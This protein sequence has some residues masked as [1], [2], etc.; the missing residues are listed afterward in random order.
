MD[1]EEFLQSRNGYSIELNPDYHRDGAAYCRAAEIEVLTPTLFDFLAD[2][3][4][5]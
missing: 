4:P 2:E 3:V 1:Y 5:A